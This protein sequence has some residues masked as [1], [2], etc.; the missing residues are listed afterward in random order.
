MKLSNICTFKQQMDSDCVIGIFSK[1][2]DGSFIESSGKS[3]IDFCILDMEH[4]PV[5]YEHLPNLIRACECTDTLPIVRVAD[6]CDEY[7]S[8]ALDLG[9]AGIQIPQISN[10]TAAE[11]AIQYAKF[12]PQGNRGVCRYV[13][14]AEYSSL[15][16]SQYFKEANKAMIILQIEGI[17]GIQNLDEILSVPGIDIIFIGPYDLSQ[18]LGLPGNV[19]HPKVIEQMKLIVKKA[20]NANVAVGTFVDTSKDAL[21]W[22]SLGVKY[23][24]NSVDVGIFYSACRAIVTS[25]KIG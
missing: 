24:A 20:Q 23:I 18:S 14:A 15:E 11:K 17:E 10:K 25:I 12:Y 3:G 6:N 21:Y 1:T 22:K 16:K 19:H 5:S 13:R 9:A 4:G 8:K 2:N 7:I